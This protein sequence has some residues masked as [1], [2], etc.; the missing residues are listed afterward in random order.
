LLHDRKEEGGTE[1][2]SHIG[3]S[4]MA[5]PTAD[6]P[7]HVRCRWWR[8][9]VVQLSRKDLAELVGVSESRIMDIEAGKTR[10]T[11]APIDA[12]TM[13][14]YRMAC[15]AVALGVEFDWLECRMR[16]VAKTEIK[17]VMEVAAPSD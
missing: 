9:F 14:R 1:P 3:I 11:G 7:E 6:D 8:D 2:P 16:P 15:A 12:A 4:P 13:Q 5:K 10:G 17:V